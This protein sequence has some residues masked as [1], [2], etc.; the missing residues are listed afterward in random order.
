MYRRRRA[1]VLL[2]LIILIVVAWVNIAN[3]G[4]GSRTPVSVTSRSGSST[5]TPTATGLSTAIAS[6]AS[7]SAAAPC[8]PRKIAVTPL[9]DANSFEAGQ[10]P[11]F[12]IG[13][14][15]TSKEACTYNVG[16]SQMSM[17]VTSGNETY[18]SSVDC[19]AE[20]SDTM[21]VLTPGK[22]EVSAPFEWS[23]EY[24]SPDT[25]SGTREAVPAGGASYYLNVQ[26]GTAKS[27]NG[28][29]FLLY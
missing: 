8:D 19:Q 23:R 18:W 25:C 3:A 4:N 22:L 6:P 16:T 28:F 11:K 5:P 10:L 13:I 7:S 9:V 2:G 12:Q 26:V 14:T 20:S 21:A 29:Q 24:S 1:L 17:T 27:A 15:N